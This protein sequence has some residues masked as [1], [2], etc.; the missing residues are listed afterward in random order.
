MKS[1][2][3]SMLKNLLKDPNTFKRFI[4]YGGRGSAKTGLT[5]AFKDVLQEMEEQQNES[6]TLY[7]N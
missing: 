1:V 3:I 4:F 7:R 2:T 6:K 5:K